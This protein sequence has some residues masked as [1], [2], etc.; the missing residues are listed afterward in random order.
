MV[1]TIKLA[2]GEEVHV[3]DEDYAILSRFTWVMGDSRTI[4]TTIKKRHGGAQAIVLYQLIT[5]GAS[6]VV[7]KDGNQFNMQKANLVVTD[8]AV[9][10]HSQ[11][12]RGATKDSAPYSRFKGVTWDK[13]N[14]KWQGQIVKD[15]RRYSKR[16][17][18]EIE[19]ASFYNEKATELFGEFARLNDIEGV[20]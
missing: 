15:G 9:G 3:D 8:H 13:R 17:T 20:A 11:P 19:A 16:F 7:W 12:K 10:A 14:H 4:R 1:K 6:R 5:G 18:T 2:G